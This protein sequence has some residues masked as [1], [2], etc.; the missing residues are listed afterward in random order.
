MRMLGVYLFAVASV[1]T[2]FAQTPLTLQGTVADPSGAFIPG[3]AVALLSGGTVARNAESDAN[4]K[5]IITAVKPGKYILKVTSTGF[6]NYERPVEI[7][8]DRTINFDIPMKLAIETQQITVSDTSELLLD[9]SDPTKNVGSLVLKGEDLQMLSDNPDDLQSDLQ[10][11]AGPAAGPNG[12]QIFIDGFSGGKL[13][14]KESIREVRINSN[15]FS[16][17]FDKL[18]FGRIEI[19]TKPGTDKFR[20]QAFFNFSD[21]AF[22]SRN[23]FATEK[24]P[25]QQRFFGGNISGPITKKSSF[26]VDAERRNVDEV[27]VVNALTIDPS[28]FNPFNYQTTLL[29]PMVRTDVSPRV[30]Y[31]INANN[32]LVARYRYSHIS[33]EN[34]GVGAQTLPTRAFNGGNTDQTVQ[35]TETAVLNAKTINETRFQYLRF[36]NDRIGD[37]STPGINVLDSFFGGGATVGLAY[38]NEDRFELTNQTSITHGT[39]MVK[40]GGRLRASKLA[41]YSTQN[42]NGTYTFSTLRAYQTQ[43]EGMANGLT[44]DQIFAMGGGPTQF[45]M[46]GG[47]PLATVPQYDVGVWLT[48]DW[49]IKPTLTISGGLRYETQTNIRSYANFAPRI[50]FAWGV[51]PLSGA[52]RAPKTVIRGGFGIFYDRFDD[53]YTLNAQRNNGINQQQ[54]RVP[55]PNFFPLVPTVDQLEQNKIAQA[56]QQVDSGLLAPYIV[57]TAIGVERQLPKNIT[58]AVNYTNSRGVHTL[59]QRNINAPLPGTVTIENPAGVQPYGNIGNIYQYESSGSFKQ[60]QVIFNV[61]ARINPKLMVF[62]FYTLNYAKSNT[63]GA[64]TFPSNSYDLGSEWGT[65]QFGIRNRAMMGGSITAPYG[66]TLNPFLIVTSGA[67]YNITIG[68]DL[69]GD[70]V[71]TDR[72]SFATDLTRPSVVRAPWGEYFDMMP[73]AGQ[74]IIPRNYGDGPGQVMFNLRASKTWGFGNRE[75]PASA[76]GQGGPPRGPMFGGGPGGPG[77]GGGGG[78]RGGGGG[79]MRGGGPGGF[80]GG[81]VSGKKYSLTFSVSAR[82]LLNHVNLGQPYGT[83]TSAL[84]GTSNTLNSGFFTNSTAN[85]RIDLQLRFTF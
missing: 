80:G 27:A 2:A 52:A 15:P 17:E 30:D 53:S 25:Y 60:N 35:I 73:I 62:G 77:G 33:Q 10:A 76:D 64:N 46:Y 40:F 29:T 16:A 11:L 63:D 6:A 58:V 19:F 78:P 43:L 1:S 81:G 18:G 66:V 5:Y 49:R 61:N 34:Q 65:A 74:T 68:R 37:N 39:H 47:N 51:G 20:G 26:F 71:F 79:G 50:G 57:Q 72:P 41:D 67:P 54:F 55:L 45:S 9:A 32:T 4:G 44:N 28:T 75:A 22:N 38:T 70:S 21:A 84:F 31:A 23:P 85:R 13:P 3:A 12:G 8:G 36:R 48:D 42:Y 14:P 83:L 82:N 7:R 24:P 59:R 69:N 56:V